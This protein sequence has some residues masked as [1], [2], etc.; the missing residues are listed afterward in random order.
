[1]LI[2]MLFCI[3]DLSGAIASS[4]PYLVLFNNTGS[5]GVAL[6]LSIL[7]FLLI[8]SGN[9]TAL[10]TTSRETWAF[11]RDHGFPCSHW[12]SK[13]LLEAL[14][15]RFDGLADKVIQ[16]NYKHNVPDNA[17]FLTSV[18]SGAIC[19]INLGSTTAF[20]IVVS[21]TLLALLSTYM[22]SIGCI[23]LKR[24]RKQDLPPARWSLGR[25]GLPVNAFAFLYSAFVIVFSSFPNQVP[26]MPST[27]N[28]APLVWIGVLLV[29]LAAYWFHG[30]THFTAPVS[31]VEGRRENGVG[32]QTFE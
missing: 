26:V 29:A 1:M 20:N 18:V 25:W 13:V 16:M 12:I 6:M 31:F 2:T 22:I 24:L 17:V 21:L 4:T 10:A 9:V 11:S 8:F 28:W 19:L 27:A 5:V 23:L 32:L 3:G 14:L 7:I 15:P 30:R